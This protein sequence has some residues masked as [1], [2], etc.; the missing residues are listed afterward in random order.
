MGWFNDLLAWKIVPSHRDKYVYATAGAVVGGIT[1]GMTGSWY[2]A[3]WWDVIAAL[4]CWGTCK[5]AAP[6][7]GFILTGKWDKS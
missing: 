7:G 1:F 3:I 4:T 6:L 2:S 5:I